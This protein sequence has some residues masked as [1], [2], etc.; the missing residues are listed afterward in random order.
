MEESAE[1]PKKSWTV[2]T[3]MNDVK[4]RLDKV[5]SLKEKELRVKLSWSG[6]LSLMVDDLEKFANGK[7]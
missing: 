2:L 3:V 7:K 1:K 6:L 4:A 5:R